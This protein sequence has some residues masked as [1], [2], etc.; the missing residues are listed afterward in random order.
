MPNIYNELL[1]QEL[2]DNFPQLNMEL[3]LNKEKLNNILNKYNIVL[4]LSYTN[5]YMDL[6]EKIKLFLTGKK[7]E[8]LSELTLKGYNLELELF[9]KHIQKKVDDISTNDIRLYLNKWDKLKTSSLS[10]RIS[11][12]KSFFGWLK[13]EEII[14]S[15]PTCKIKNP[16]KEKRLPKALTIEELELVRE[17]CKTIRERAMIEVYYATGSRL[18]ELHNTN[19]FTDIDWRSMTIR[20]VGKG[21]KERKTYF[22]YKALFHLKKYLNSRTD[23]DSALFVT[24][25]KPYRR[26]SRRGIQQEIKKIAKRCGLEKKLHCHVLRHSLATNLLGSGA[27]LSTIK[28]ILGHSD[29]STTEIYAQV[30]DEHINQTYKK[31]FVQ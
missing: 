14:P 11:V 18:S 19:R 16:K 1:Q 17:S 30:T 21:S 31:C 6:Q 15:D 3:Q 27:D 20:V 10:R 8:G 29:I 13:N 22:S 26:L 4:I 7:L 28:E 5:E 23:D 12:L 9:S 2:L 25:R 24:E